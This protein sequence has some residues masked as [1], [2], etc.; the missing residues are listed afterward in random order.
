ML[1]KIDGIPEDF[2]IHQRSLMHEILLV[3]KQELS[4]TQ[5]KQLLL[6][7]KLMLNDN[8]CGNTFKVV[9]KK[10]EQT[11]QQNK[12]NKNLHRH[13]QPEVLF[14]QDLLAWIKQLEKNYGE[15]VLFP[16]LFKSKFTFDLFN[17]DLT[18]NTE[19]ALKLY[20]C[21]SEIAY[22]A[23][24][25]N[26]ITDNDKYLVLKEFLDPL[27]FSMDL[28][29]PTI[30]ATINKNCK[31]WDPEIYLKDVAKKMDGELRDLNIQENFTICAQIQAIIMNSLDYLK[32]L[33]TSYV[34]NL[35]ESEL[36]KLASNCLGLEKAPEYKVPSESISPKEAS[37]ESDSLELMQ[38]QEDSTY[39]LRL[40]KPQKKR[41]PR[42]PTPYP[43]SV[44]D[45]PVEESYK[46]SLSK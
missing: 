39:E 3:L 34:L 5:R 21:A 1:K 15:V 4:V 31:N 7:Q 36:K 20:N 14:D 43:Q 11:I 13:F 8:I 26:V 28:L 45:F 29:N 16:Q 42:A 2:I 35:S 32:I 12:P 23:A 17:S 25:P 40:L 30:F 46:I 41:R 10:W 44:Y 18:I 9:V 38:A 37:S 22:V 19:Q 24:L 6:L 33:K 27:L